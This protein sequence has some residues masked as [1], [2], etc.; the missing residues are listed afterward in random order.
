MIELLL[1]SFP[2]IFRYYQLKRRGEVMTLWNIKAA[3]YSWAVLAFMLFVVIFYFHPKTYSGILPF[4]KVSVVTQT[5]G[6]VTAIN[7]SD[8]SRVAA[9]DVLFEIENSTQQAAL[10]QAKTQFDVINASETKAG[11]ALKAAVANVDQAQASLDQIDFDLG[12]ARTLLERKVG[13]ADAVRKL[14][15]QRLTAQATMVVAQ[16][17]ATVAQTDL[18]VAIPAQ[19]TAA[20]ATV[21]AAQVELG[22][23]LVRSFASG[24][25]T[26]F[27]L[28]VGSPAST[29]I[30]APAMVIIPDRNEGARRV[31][32]AGF[33]QVARAT[34]YVGMPAEL[35]CDSNIG[36]S[37]R[38]SVLPARVTS[39]Q[40]AIATGQVVP[41]PRV[42]T[43]NQYMTVAARAQA[44]RN[45]IGHLS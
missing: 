14:E 45:R 29:L 21:D 1:A 4:R 10:T 27:A 25:V 38:D 40:P 28:S 13:T 16:A 31:I 39:I 23:T 7:V 8:G 11:E 43:H 6:P 24:T 19:R 26:Q 15:T 42:R 12:S 41:G 9:G 37:F 22:K 3:V 17:Q 2:V 20:Q 18:D 34:L 33:N 44:E 30:L 5:S 32:V 35:A 36:L